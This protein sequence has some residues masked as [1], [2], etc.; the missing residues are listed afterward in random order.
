MFACFH[1]AAE[2]ELTA[3]AYETLTSA[4]GELPLLKPMSEATDEMLLQEGAK[5]TWR[6]R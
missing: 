5:H 3:V 4:E 6:S 2:R 1:C